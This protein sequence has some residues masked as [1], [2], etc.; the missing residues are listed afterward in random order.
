M[1]QCCKM[2]GKRLSLHEPDVSR[3]TQ[4]SRFDSVATATGGLVTHEEAPSHAN[5]RATASVWFLG[6]S[7]E[8][9]RSYSPP[10]PS[11]GPM[12]GAD[13]RSYSPPYPVRRPLSPSYPPNEVPGISFPR[14]LPAAGDSNPSRLCLLPYRQ[15]T[16]PKTSTA[17]DA[18]DTDI[19]QRIA[20]PVLNPGE[21]M[22]I[23]PHE[24][25]LSV[26]KELHDKLDKWS[27]VEGGPASFFRSM[28]KINFEVGLFMKTL[29]SINEMMDMPSDES[30][31]ASFMHL[32]V[33]CICLLYIFVCL[34]SMQV[35][36]SNTF[37]FYAEPTSLV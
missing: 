34:V 7:H 22:P 4:K 8:E 23:F 36:Y 24:F 28:Q 37:I 31:E 30:F 6:R 9:A 21:Y 33:C 18:D 20:L 26:I 12:N 3:T 35:C 2:S 11:Y 17:D 19:M 16:P 10:S 29:L 25:H 27:I 32:A 1:F 13:A 5:V 14:P 15:P